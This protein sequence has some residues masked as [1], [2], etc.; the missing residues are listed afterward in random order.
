MLLN[1]GQSL[2]PREEN[3]SLDMIMNM[4]LRMNGNLI[5]MLNVIIINNSRQKDK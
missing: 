5:E 2:N 3:N 4:Q 1:H